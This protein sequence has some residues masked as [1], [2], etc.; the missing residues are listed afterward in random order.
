M[1][2]SDVCLVLEGTYPY[3]AGGVSSWAHNLILSQPDLTF[4]LV[5]ILPPNFKR[6]FK[7]EVPDNVISISHIEL[8][9]VPMGA[10]NLSKKLRQELFQK[11]E[12]PILHLQYSAKIS[13]LKKIIEAL[14]TGN[15]EIGT[16]VLLNSEE[17]WTMLLRMY[18]SSIGEGSFLNFFWSWRGLLAGMYSILLAEIPPSKVYHSLCTGYAGLF[19]ARAHLETDSPCLLTEHGIYTNER[20]IEITAADWLNDQKA[21]NLNIIQPH[22]ERDLKDYWIDTFSG[23]SKLCYEACNLIV[24][25]YEGNKSFQIEDGADPGRIQIIPNGVDFEKYVAIE[26]V[27]DHPPTVA[28]IGRVVSIKDIKT[29]IRAIGR[30]KEKIPNIRA[31]IMGPTD[32]EKEYFEECLELLASM[33]LQET[34]TFTGKVK[35]SDYL[36]E[37][38]MIALTS[39]SEAQPLVILEAGAAGIPFVATDVGSCRE[40]AFGRSDEV[41]NLGQAGDICPL[42]NPN[43]VAD[44]L[45]HFMSDSKFYNTCQKALQERIKTYYHKEDQRK[46][47]A[48]IYHD[49]KEKTVWQG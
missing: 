48:G 16:D 49:L 34:L 22:Y 32:E 46:A 42:A 7:Y 26:K 31:F 12:I 36:G 45:Y 38:D 15:H 44:S 35:I 13:I 3:I 41:P 4:S 23:Y 39:I 30:L 6:V 20:R 25:L 21:M 17:A 11:I 37:I 19:M 47:Y 18:R 24:T 28:L 14:K 40:L 2:K 27:I 5:C 33:E 10:P 8:Q 1:E 29:Y 9:E 43:A